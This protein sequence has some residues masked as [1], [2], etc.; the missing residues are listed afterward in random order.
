MIAV[1]AK[2]LGKSYREGPVEVAAVKDASLRLAQG[3]LVLL[4]GPSGS[5]KTTLLCLLGCL[6]SPDEGRLRVLG[7]DV[8]WAAPSLADVRRS[9]GFVFQQFNLLSALTVRENVQVPLWIS[10]TPRPLAGEL[11]DEAL[12]LVSLEHRAR[13][14]PGD[15]SGGEKQR[16]A[17]AR[18]VASGA[19][20]LL[21]DEP[22]GNLDSRTGR[23]I[24]RLLRSLASERDAAVLVVTHDDRQLSLA[25]RVLV[26]RDGELSES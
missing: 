7:E 10:G 11:A 23:Q 24:F 25:D 16:V 8:R 26:M 2:N 6:L 9:F 18:A 13:F 12:E 5:G 20:I 14:L 21:A 17:I 1:E 19:P 22:T 15:L 3:E 4:L